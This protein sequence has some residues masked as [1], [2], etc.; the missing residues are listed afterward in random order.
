M[1][2]EKI[3][4]WGTGGGATIITGILK[5]V[6]FYIENDKDK[7]S[8]PFLERRVYYSKDFENWKD[9]YIYIY[10]R[11]YEEI[12]MQLREIGLEENVDFVKFDISNY[13][14]NVNIENNIIEF[15]QLIKKE[16]NS[17]SNSVFYFASPMFVRE[18]EKYIEWFNRIFDKMKADKFVVFSRHIEENISSISDGLRCP[19]VGMPEFWDFCKYPNKK[20]CEELKSEIITFFQNNQYLK[21]ISNSIRYCYKDMQPNYEYIYV[22][23]VYKLF[24]FMVETLNPKCIIMWAALSPTHCIIDYVCKEKEINVYANHEGPLYGTW[25]FDSCGEHGESL[26]VIF[27]EQFRR[28]P[29]QESD[30]CNAEKILNE[31]KLTKKNRRLQPVIE[32]V[33]ELEKIREYRPTIT[34]L[35]DDDFGMCLVPPSERIKRNFSPLF[36]SGM[37]EAIYLYK[38]AEKNNWNF[39]YKPHPGTYSYRKDMFPKKFRDNTIF[40]EKMNINK[41]I[42]ISDVVVNNISSCGYL[43]LIEGKP[44]VATGRTT[45]FNAGCTYEVESLEQ[46]EGKIKQ[47]LQKGYTIE[48]KNAFVQHMALLLKYYLYNGELGEEFNY[49]MSL[50]DSIEGFDYV[51]EQLLK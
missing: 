48:M 25:W 29:L 4:V 13:S 35:G 49:G 44:V 33:E 32:D 19:V 8:K 51:K 12:A 2:K 18:R 41:V 17:L 39:I 30:I 46:L 43:S 24:L 37:E 14:T 38:I 36:A 1:K 16:K 20:E 45:Y 42:N 27:G 23:N 15:E 47:A 40:I 3:A 6:D 7:C 22:Y 21:D 26:P 11:H 10:P 28:L 5:E 34:F 9:T 50:P 31:I